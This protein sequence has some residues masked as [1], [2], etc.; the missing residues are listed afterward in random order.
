MDPHVTRHIE[1]IIFAS[2]HPIE[3]SEIK[4]V[5][6]EALDLKIGTGIVEDHIEY[7]KQRYSEDDFSF[8][9]VKI[10]GGYQFMTKGAFHNSVGTLLRINTKKR[11]SRV[12]LETLAIIAYKQP[13]SKSEIESIR[14]V[15]SDYAVQKL[16]EKDLIKI[17]G[18]SDGPGRPLLY[19][20]SEKFFE[21]FGLEDVNAL[22]KPKDF[23]TVENSIGEQAPIEETVLDDESE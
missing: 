6:T 10:K 15:S 18:R 21:Y 11:L 9:V 7:L 14:G 16:L 22:P 3:A 17:D 12:A 4:K 2:D 8:E 19:S 20:T 13:V 23:S 1:S 5:L